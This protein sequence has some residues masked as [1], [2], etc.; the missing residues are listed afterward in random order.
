MSLKGDKKQ[1]YRYVKDK[2][3]VRTEIGQIKMD[4]GFLTASNVE[5]ASTL[6]NSLNQ[7]LAE[8][9]HIRIRKRE[10]LENP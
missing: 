5:T 2:Q 1:F 9:T 4:N 7:C 10:R 8:K 6:E 3:Q